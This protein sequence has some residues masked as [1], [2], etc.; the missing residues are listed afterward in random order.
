MNIQP[1]TYLLGDNGIFPNSRLPVL[2]YKQALALPFFFPS[3]YVKKIF[4]ANGWTNNWRNGI[5]TFHHYHSIT[6]EALGV[7]AGRAI[8][9]LGGEDGMHVMIEK[10]DVLI[11]PAGVA[12]KNLGAEHDVRCVGGYPSGSDYDVNEGKE[13][14]RPGTD[15]RIAVVPVPES[16]PV[17]GDSGLPLLWRDHR[18]IAGSERSV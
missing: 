10:G 12:H 13:G 9:L 17:F 3:A 16:D 2:H 4:R 1:L 14:E 11:I 5:F 6:H 8:I 7:Y 15:H 18:F